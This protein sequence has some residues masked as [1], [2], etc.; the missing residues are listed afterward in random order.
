[1]T[2][3][4]PTVKER[5]LLHLLDHTK[6]SGAYEAPPAA[7]Q[8]GIAR[9]AWFNIQHVPQ[10]IRPL[11]GEGLVRERTAHVR[12]GRRRRKVYELTDSGQRQAFAMRDQLRDEAILVR[13]GD[14]MR[15]TT[16][17]DAVEIAR[18]KLSMLDVVREFLLTGSVDVTSPRRQGA[19]QTVRFL[20]D[21]PGV[22]G[23][24]G[25]DRELTSIVHPETG[26]RVFVVR[27][28]AGIGKSSLGAKVCEMLAEDHHI[29][30]HRVRPWDSPHSLFAGLA[31]FLSAAG[32]SAPK[33]ALE[34]KDLSNAFQVLR[35]TLAEV[36]ALFVIDD[37]H[38][39]G[40]ELL[41]FFRSLKSVVADAPET[42]LLVLTR[43]FLGFYDRRDVALEGVLREIDLTG[44]SAEEVASF[45]GP[46]ERAR[47]PEG[48]ASHPLFLRLLRSAPGAEAPRALRNIEEFVHET[49]DAELSDAQR[50]I[51][52]TASLFEVPVSPDSLLADPAISRHDVRAVVERALLLPAGDGIEVHD[53]LRPFFVNALTED[54]RA[55]LGQ[56]VADR[57]HGLAQR[58]EEEGELPRALTCLFNALKVVPSPDG[59]ASFAEAIGDRQDRMG[60][61]QGSAASYSQAIRAGGKPAAGRLHRKLASIRIVQGNLAEAASEIER[62]FGALGE[63]S[64]GERGWLHLARCRLGIRQD[65]LEEAL[66]DGKAALSFFQVAGDSVG[67]GQSLYQLAHIEIGRPTGSAEQG[68][69]LL[70]RALQLGE[71]LDDPAFLATVHAEL[72]FLFGYR[73]GAVEKAS[74]HL[75]SVESLVGPTEIS[76]RRANFLMLRGLLG[77]QTGDFRQAEADYHE[78]IA[79][80]RKLQIGAIWSYARAGLAD[81]AVYEGRFAEAQTALDA[82]VDDFKEQGAVASV[83]DVAC[84]AA[85]TCLLRGDVEGYRQRMKALVDGNHDSAA[86]S[87]SIQVMTLEAIRS[88]L[89]GREQ[90]AWAVLDEALV[91]SE[92]SRP[93]E[94]WLPRFIYAQLL[95]AVGQHAEAQRHR[96]LAVAILESYS[97][98]AELRFLPKREQLISEVL[99]NARVRT[100]VG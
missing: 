4:P 100:S 77:Q 18:G 26:A 5:I 91:H 9:A 39:A 32:Y 72:A 61:L 47:I 24:V 84:S 27:G 31:A 83:V 28:V 7:T 62:G 89:D 12:Q 81:I 37:A 73:L 14:G 95:R 50:R 40:P 30:W 66:E 34:E 16:V 41:A 21:A 97:R 74:D 46:A 23:F 10:Y 44:L 90:A 96:D 45:L 71:T 82:L 29:F 3:R 54:D 94:T 51:M 1:M 58:A 86:S 42:K 22:E 99:R 15:E 56:F 92:R 8:A 98:T 75:R 64:D 76:F 17:R 70:E 60:D 69:Q 67:Q 49:I 33:A 68:Q 87:R 52:K 59:V 85:E 65:E 88:F 48:I 11:I 79:L 2:L 53:A 25:R 57:L 35:G 93:M 38:D 80:A 63:S 78:A 13:D 6:S 20:K 55:R 36:R 43:R 19:G